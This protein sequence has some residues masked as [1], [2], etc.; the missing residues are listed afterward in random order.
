MAESV[1]R[2][3]RRGVY[4]QLTNAIE[5]ARVL[6]LD[7]RAVSHDLHLL[8]AYRSPRVV[9]TAAPLPPADTAPS[10]GETEGPMSLEGAR[11]FGFERVEPLAGNVGYIDLRFFAEGPGVATAAASVMG[12]LAGTDAIIVDLRQNTGGAPAAGALI[13]S[14]FFDQETTKLYDFYDRDDRLTNSLSTVRDLPGPGL[15]DRDL[16]VLTSHRTISGGEALAYSLKTMKRATLVGETTRGA[17]H[18]IEQRP[19]GDSFMMRLPTGRPV[20]PITHT[21]WEQVG[22]KPDVAV[23]APRA[24]REAHALAVRRLGR[25]VM[26]AQ[27]GRLST[28]ER[29]LDAPQRAAPPTPAASVDSNGPLRAGADNIRLEPRQ[30]SPGCESPTPERGEN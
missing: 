22:V 20:S 23:V 3:A 19:L 27:L 28:A 11:A 21:S 10:G 5:L 9:A 4:D 15:G 6:T 2:R 25:A 12:E 29:S 18:T 8:I 7:M 14:Y 26:P 1:E 16:Y 24:L 17:A 13:T 30:P